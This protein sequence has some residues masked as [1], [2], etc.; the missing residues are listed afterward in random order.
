[1]VA[2]RTEANPLGFTAAVREQVRTLD[3]DQSISKVRSMD[4]LVDEQVGQRRLL[5]TLLGSFA[6][7]ALLLVLMGIY[8]IIAYSA[9][10]RT[11]EV[12]IRRALGAQQGDILRVV[13]GESLGLAV[14][15]VAVG[16]AGAFGL[17]RLVKSFLF[18]VS[19]TDPATFVAVALLF[20]CV[21]LAASYIP[22]R[23][24]IRIDPVAALRF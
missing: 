7:M 17:T 13:V 10:Q 8:G 14:A 21:T 16:V 11:Q 20:L 15:G 23:H 12:G 22:A 6:M 19:A 4:D 5:V 3:R 2:V 9:A 1:M 18:H 24:A